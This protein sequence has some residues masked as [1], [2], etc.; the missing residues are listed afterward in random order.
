[1]TA[2]D[3]DGQILEDNVNITVNPD[4][5]EYSV[6]RLTGWGTSSGEWKI[7][8]Q[9]TDCAVGWDTLVVEV[10]NS[11]GKVGSDTTL[12]GIQPRVN[13]APVV[14]VPEKDSGFVGDTVKY[15]AEAFD[16]DGDSLLD[17]AN[18]IIEPDCGSIIGSRLTGKGTSSGSWEIVFYTLVCDPGTYR[19]IVEIEDAL[20]AKG[21]GTTY[22]ELKQP[23]GV[24]EESSERITNFLLKQNYPNPFNLNTEISFL[25]AYQ[26]KA[27]LKIYNLKGQ[28][29][30]TLV[31]KEMNR[32][33][34]TVFWDGTDNQGNPVASGI[35]F[36]KLKTPDFTSVRKM[37]LLK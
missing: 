13:N 31:E 24:D 30:K 22:V 37:I 35:Y 17:N 34:H 28:L 14:T 4:C 5:G 2:Y 12:L 26:C 9:A 25:L 21:A 16:P 10:Q 19:V 27:D 36:Y 3:P 33:A 29:V 8:F 11:C 20:G 7:T 18:I 32:G 23:S 6:E 1:M 15:N